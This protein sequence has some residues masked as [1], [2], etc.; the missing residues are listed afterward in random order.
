M[1]FFL[2]WNSLWKWMFMFMMF[3]KVSRRGKPMFMCFCR[4]DLCNAASPHHLTVPGDNKQ[5]NKL[6]L[7]YAREQPNQSAMCLFLEKS[8]EQMSKNKTK[9]KN[10]QFEYCPNNTTHHHH[11]RPG[12][13]SSSCCLQSLHHCHQDHLLLNFNLALISV[14]LSCS[15]NLR[16]RQ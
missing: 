11:C 2:N 15:E 10:K 1:L 14:L 13:W 8:V 9:Q 7:W 4:G 12:W 6:R 16:K 5:T 3:I